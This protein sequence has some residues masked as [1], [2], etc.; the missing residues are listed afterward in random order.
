MTNAVANLQTALQQAMVGRPKAG[1][2]PYLAETLRRAEV[3][4]N[5]WALPSCQS[6]YWTGLGAVVMQG[7]PLALGALEVPPFDEEALVAALR[8]D[9]AGEGSFPEFLAAA[10]RAGVIDYDVDFE[11]RT[12]TYRGASGESY[13]EAYPAVDVP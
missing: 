11:G 9:Q 7:Q 5:R 6:T 10:W 2:F 4:R 1:G 8:R 12:V 3:R 13:V